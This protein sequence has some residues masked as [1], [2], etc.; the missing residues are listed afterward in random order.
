MMG[1]SVKVGARTGGAVVGQGSVLRSSR[2]RLL[3][4]VSLLLLTP[5]VAEP[6]MAACVATITSTSIVSSQSACG[7]TWTGGN[8]TI[9]STGGFDDSTISSGVYASGTVGTLLNQGYISG[10]YGAFNSGVMT[11]AIN[12]GTI[13]A[14]SGNGFNN[15]GTLGT[16]SNSGTIS[17]PKSGVYTYGTINTVNNSGLITAQGGTFSSY[18]YSTGVQVYHGKIGALNNSVTGTIQGQ[19]YG[20]Y[21]T[22]AG[23]IGTLANSGVISGGRDAIYSD[24]GT[25]GTLINSGTI[26]GDIDMPTALTIAGGAGTTVGTLTGYSAGSQGTITSTAANLVFSSGN[27]LVNDL[28]NATGHTVVN[29]GSTLTVA[30]VVNVIGNYS[31]SAGSLIVSGGGEL[32][33]NGNAS[34]TG[35]AVKASL[36]STGNYL[37]GQTIN[38]VQGST[39]SNYAAA[40]VTVTGAQVGAAVATITTTGTVLSMSEGSPVSAAATVKVLQ[41]QLTSDYVGGTLG[42]IGNTGTLGATY[43]V[44]VGS[45][46]TLGTLS[47][48][49]TIAGTNYGVVVQGTLGY[50]ANSVG[51]T[52]GGRTGMWIPGTIGTLSNAGLIRGASTAIYLS[53]VVNTLAN[54]G[55]ISAESIALD[56]RGSIGTLNNSGTISGQSTAAL[57]LGSQGSIGTLVNSGTIAGDITNRSANA[58]TIAGGSG[59]TI[60]TLTGYAGSQGTLTSENAELVFASGN[61]LVNDLLVTDSH[62]VVNNG[63]S[64]TLATTTN[65]IGNYSQSAGNVVLRSGAE[66]VVSGTASIT[67]GTVKGSLSSTANY[68]AG[69]TVDLVQGS[70]LSSYTGAQVAVTGAKVGAIAATTVTSGTVLSLSEG[71]PV[72]S[73]ATV[74]VLQA[75]LTS[76]YVGGNLTSI[77]NTGSIGATYGVYVASTGTL[78]TLSNSGTIAGSSVG[79]DMLGTLGTLSNSGTITGGAGV[80]VAGIGGTV[81][82]S[83]VISGSLTGV[84]VSGTLGTLINS[85]TVTS[86]DVAV[87]VA[88]SG[89]LGVLMNSG[90]LSGSYTAVAISQHFLGTLNNS[91]LITGASAVYVGTNGTLGTLVNSGTIAGDIENKSATA[92]TIVGGSGGTV[93]TLTGY[94]AGSQGTIR[95]TG[96]DVVFASGTTQL[97]DAIDVGTHTVVNSGATLDLASTVSITGNYSQATGTLAL[98]AYT[99]VVGGVTSISG[100][101]ITTTQLDAA[102]NYLAGSGTGTL[103]QGGTG[104]SYTGVDITSGITGLEVATSVVTIGGTVDLLLQQANDYVGGTLANLDNTGTIA[105]VQTAAYVAATGTIGTLSNSGVLD[106]TRFGIRNVGSVGLLTNSG[107]VTGVVGLYNQGTIGTVLNTGSLVD[108]PSYQASGLYNQGS[109]GLVD[110]RGTI[111]G[112]AYGLYN[113]GTI[114]SLNNSGVISGATALYTSGSLGTVANSGTIAGNVVNTSANDLVIVGGSNGTVGVFTGGTIS[115]AAANLVFASGDLSLD[116]AIDVT[117]H[118]VTNAGANLTLAADVAVTGNY[119]QSAGTLAVAGHVLNVSGTA[120]ISGGV[121]DA[122]LS[123]TANYLA[124][125]SATLVQ[126]GAGSSYAPSQVASGVGGLTTSGVTSGDTLLAVAANDYIGGTLASAVNNGTISLTNGV[127]LY[128]AAAGSIGTFTNNGTLANRSAW[129]VYN[130]GAMGTLDNSGLISSASGFG[131]RN[132]GGIGLLNNSGTLTAWTGLYNASAIESL[133]NSGTILASASAIVDAGSIGTLVN[134]GTILGPNALVIEAGGTLGAL[135]DSG[136]II[137]AVTNYSSNDLVIS[138]G[139]DDAPG[140]LTGGSGSI[141]QITNTLANLRFV[142]GTL[143]LNDNLNVGSHSV[144]NS[145]ATLLVNS[146]INITG[147]Y[148]QTAGS[149]VIGVASTSSYGSLV[150]SGSASLTGGSVTLKATSGSLAAGSYTIVSAGT[151]LATSNLVLTA[152]GYTV[153]SSTVT[154]GGK[155]DLVLTL[156]TASTGTTSS[157]TGT[158]G[159]GTGTG[160][161]GTDT[162]GTDTGSGSTGSGTTTTTKPS[163]NYTAVGQAQGGAAVGTGAALDV[164]AASGSNAAQAVQSAILTPLNSLTGTARQ[165]AVAQLAPSQLT[166]QL[167]ATVV[168]PTTT[169]ISQHQQTVAGLMDSYGQTGAAAGDGTMNGVLWGEILGGGALRANATDA[170]GYRASSGGIVLGGDW[171]INPEVMAGLAFSWLNS[172]AVGQGVSAGSLTRVA[173][174]QLTA[175]SAWRPDFAEQRLSVQG[176]VAFGYNHYDQRRDID[177]LG[178]RANANYGG[179]Q[180]VGKVTVGYAM[181]DHNGFTLTPQWSLQAARLTNHAYSEHDAGVADLAVDA[182]TTNSLSQEV[183]FKLDTV[184]NTGIGRLLPD[185]KLAWVHDYLSGPVSTTGVLGGVSFAS[186]T[187]RVSADG[188]AIGLGATLAKGDNL[189]LRLE[190][191]GDLRSDYQSHAGVLRASWNF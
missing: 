106:G 149:L 157:G 47:N 180:Y 185:L 173:T 187:G 25:I 12:S 49:G 122:G 50:V 117:G 163:T 15:S 11:A 37:A 109:I 107:T 139:T 170:A 54:S 42:S 143:L 127:P 120:V 18:I 130:G 21:I 77:G 83:G 141:G 43:G 154:S 155:T 166:P 45:T 138:G 2:A 46:G 86:A 29:S 35:G 76:D 98:G 30:S 181:P 1:R 100:G 190:Y 13:V 53:G 103:V 137:G 175:Y 188:V 32:V 133:V 165:V 101:A 112:E 119:S 82:N 164:I 123:A 60:G 73:T 121:V 85:G 39:L 70:T 23:T 129:A 183:G 96:A 78:G 91:G 40:Q 189:S 31:Q 10:V 179:E 90:T 62:T 71:S 131:I 89:T 72:S 184:F 140:T 51:A 7:A 182:M 5:A 176:Q 99:L 108:A 152:A 110:N 171:Y 65:I 114:D 38:L 174:Y 169:A 116:D 186:T 58:L 142:S 151:S 147:S 4:G 69:Q 14:V 33:V 93:G 94:T 48:S 27:L 95:S 111:S 128:V 153:T 61:L 55:T 41:A 79:V 105:S 22:S 161:A 102:G 3:A 162:T 74:K 145:G 57:Y 113:R 52:I 146:A 92:L 167:T 63:A 191:T 24:G 59:S 178:A 64:L 172:D 126:G 20:V 88:A 159:T 84:R 19:T 81:D 16:L 80:Q 36:A 28:I 168:T 150:I 9:T 34:I 87:Q 44:Y 156:S 17:A 118:T 67:G 160:T 148:S 124:G 8:L 115:N 68:L 125:D 158:S 66:L 26:A 177:F 104:S 132:Y 97:N 135:V 136:T 75:L 134:S 6:A 56:V 144:V